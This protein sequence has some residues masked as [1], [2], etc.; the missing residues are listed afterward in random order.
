MKF[1]PI[2]EADGFPDLKDAYSE[3]ER[4]ALTS[5]AF[6]LL[7]TA[8]SDLGYRHVALKNLWKADQETER[9][10]DECYQEVLEGRVEE[11]G[12]AIDAR[13]GNILLANEVVQR[14]VYE[15]MGRIH[16]VMREAGT[17][18]GDTRVEQYLLNFTEVE[19]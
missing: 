7:T 8:M 13:T 17:V 2:W 9:M 1:R 18:F 19:P 16:E 12:I 15:Q 11:H 10:L 5:G 6:W 4:A 3:E 14:D